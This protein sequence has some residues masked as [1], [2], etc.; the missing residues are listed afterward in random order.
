M[1]YPNMP[2]VSSLNWFEL[3]MSFW[4]MTIFSK[5]NLLIF[6]STDMKIIIKPSSIVRKSQPLGLGICYMQH[7]SLT[8]SRE[9]RCFLFD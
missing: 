8:A 7:G 2:E 1:N 9:S 6:V 3:I 5:Q 4:F